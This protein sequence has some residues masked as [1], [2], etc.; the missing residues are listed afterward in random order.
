[1]SEDLTDQ[2]NLELDH[3]RRN[4]TTNKIQ[5]LTGTLTSGN[6]HEK[7]TVIH[8]KEQTVTTTLGHSIKNSF[9]DNANDV[10]DSLG[11]GALEVQEQITDSVSSAQSQIS[12]I[13][14]KYKIKTQLD[15]GG[16]IILNNLKDG[17][18]LIGEN[19][20]G[21]VDVV[22]QQIQNID[23]SK[24]QE[25]VVNGATSL[26]QT[27]KKGTEEVSASI[28]LNPIENSN[29][30]SNIPDS[31][32][33]QTFAALETIQNSA[34]SLGETISE[35]VSSTGED[36]TNL[37][38]EGVVATFDEIM[39]GALEIGKHIGKGTKLVGKEV[40]K[41]TKGIKNNVNTWFTSMF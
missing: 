36:I 3:S 14:K 12:H 4:M 6:L 11:N 37:A 24:I 21:G 19:I 18:E 32:E 23:T 17:A 41:V 13:N 34:G 1:M 2:L 25:D 30:P 40:T 35:T 39:N 38:G 10:I 26:W 27:I 28:P 9:I 20:V 22:Q 31:I 5:R 15:V 8:K 16:Q 7:Q 33:D 29:K